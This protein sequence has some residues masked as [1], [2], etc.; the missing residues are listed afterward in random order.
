MTCSVIFL[1]CK[2][3]P[4]AL[5][6]IIGKSSAMQLTGFVGFF[7][8]FIPKVPHIHFCITVSTHIL[9][10][11]HTLTKTAASWI[12]QTWSCPFDLTLYSITRSRPCTCFSRCEGRPWWFTTNDLPEGE[13]SPCR[14]I[15]CSHV[16]ADHYHLSSYMSG[17]GKYAWFSL[18]G[19]RCVLI[20][21]PPCCQSSNGTSHFCWLIWN[22]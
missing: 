15:L 10:D 17:S 19:K 1:S 18:L 6:I 3:Y 4:A 11:V 20:A 7:L 13:C 21:G 9:D 16:K 8:S 22:K 14:C 5:P 2:K 12:F